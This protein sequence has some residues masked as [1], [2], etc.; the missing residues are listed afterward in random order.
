[1]ASGKP[2]PG[3][4]IRTETIE[5]LGVSPSAFDRTYYILVPEDAKKIDGR[6]TWIHFPTL[7]REIRNK[8]RNDSRKQSSPAGQSA[9][10]SIEAQRIVQTK[11]KEI[12]LRQKL[13]ELVPVEEVAPALAKFASR[14]A[15]YGDTI[16]RKETTSGADVQ[17]TINEIVDEGMA[18]CEALVEGVD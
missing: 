12:E 3:W 4:R 9:D 5:L 15:S 13:R 11:L 7:L 2:G 18:A 17:R 6:Q 8:E 1:M 14:L 16:G 10:G